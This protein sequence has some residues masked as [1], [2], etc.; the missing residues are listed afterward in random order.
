M[1]LG[2]RGEFGSFLVYYE[3]ELKSSVKG[4][5]SLDG[6]TVAASQ[7]SAEPYCLQL[8]TRIAAP[9]ITAPRVV[10]MPRRMLPALPT[11]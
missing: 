4:Y 8:S 7:H 1:Q 10:A 11:S 6:A 9:A 2:P 5:I 3:S